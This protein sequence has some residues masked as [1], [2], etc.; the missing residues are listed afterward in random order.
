MQLRP[1]VGT[2]TDDVAR[3]GWNFWLVEDDIEHM[4]LH[5]PRG[6]ETGSGLGDETLGQA[7]R[8]GPML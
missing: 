6:L 3:V 5:Y 7:L 2:Q 1:G 4:G 8:V